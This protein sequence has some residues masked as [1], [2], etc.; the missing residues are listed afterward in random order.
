MTARRVNRIRAVELQ[1][2][3]AKYE[4]ARAERAY[5]QYE[6]ENRLVAR[7]QELRWKAKPVALAEAALA[8]HACKNYAV[9]LA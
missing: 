7:G 4:A 9:A 1:V 2:E 8:A 3:R 5:H 6:P